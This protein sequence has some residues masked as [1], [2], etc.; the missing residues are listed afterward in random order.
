MSVHEFYKFHH[1]RSSV[2]ILL[3][4]FLPNI[5]KVFTYKSTTCMIII[6]THPVHHEC[7]TVSMFFRDMV[8]SLYANVLVQPGVSGYLSKFCV[9]HS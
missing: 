5:L 6:D 8:S 1:A 2:V 7:L 4:I 9:V 3:N